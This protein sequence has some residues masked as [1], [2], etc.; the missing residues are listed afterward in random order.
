M[1]F[2][3]HEFALVGAIQKMLEQFLDAK[4]PVVRGDEFHES[5][6][7]PCA[8]VTHLNVI[9]PTDLTG[10]AT[11]VVSVRVGVQ[12]TIE[13]K[14]DKH[15]EVCGAVMDLVF[16]D[17]FISRVNNKLAEGLVIQQVE[18]PARSTSIDTDTGIRST[19][20]QLDILC[21]MDG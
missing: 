11:M 13:Q 18:R 14:L 12:T 8:F 4:Y 20:Q 17:D 15:I 5:I 21:S 3:V 2:N 19:G 9:E 7:Y 6:S 16:N 10:T 1:N